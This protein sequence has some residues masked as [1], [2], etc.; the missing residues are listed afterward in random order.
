MTD[1]DK[2]EIKRILFDGQPAEKLALFGFKKKDGVERIY[3]KFQLFSTNYPRYFEHNPAPFH[4]KMLKGYI[5]AYIG[6]RNF[7]NIAFRGSAKTTLLKLLFVFFLL[8]DE[9]HSRKYFKVLTKDLKNSKQV[10]TDI[11]NLIVEVSFI[12]GDS[13]KGDGKT[14]REETMSAFVIGSKGIT[15]YDEETEEELDPAVLGD[16]IKLM[17]G[18]IGQTQRGHVQDAYRPDFIWFDDVEDRESADSTVITEK[19]ISRMDEAIQGL[20]VDG[21]YICTANY[22]TDIGV[23]QNMISKDVDVMIT[24]LLDENGV[25]TWDYFTEEKCTKIRL[26]AEDW[27]GEYMCDPVTGANREFK[28]EYFHPIKLARVMEKNTRA[29]LT[30]DSAVKKDEGAD[31]SGFTLNFVCTENKWHFKSWREKLNTG[32]LIEKIFELWGFWKPKGLEAIGLEETMAVVAIMPF[33]EEEMRKRNV[34]IK[35]VLLKHGGT[36]KET[37]IRG[38]IPRYTSGSIYHIEEE[39]KDL[40][41]ELLRFPSSKND[42]TSDSAAYQEQIAK[43]PY[44]TAE[45]NIAQKTNFQRFGVDL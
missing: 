45:T 18:T 14:K 16:G 22:I 11:Y 39:C 30:I 7:L 17:A 37:R 42:D 43:K 5:R 21:S 13:F 23:I 34:Y 4:E 20:S 29:F 44:E 2:A 28:K 15:R 6:G 27:Y 9:E 19:I 31:Y 8:N 10:V 32:E 36:K 41:G 38:L 35:I 3:K 1:K 24:P 33:L 25:P 40:E 26:D 12:Y